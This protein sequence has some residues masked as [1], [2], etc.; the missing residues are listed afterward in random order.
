M[1][2]CT[3]VKHLGPSQE[4]FS[5]PPNQYRRQCAG[6]HKAKIDSRSHAVTVAQLHSA[7][8]NH[9][10]HNPKECESLTQLHKQHANNDLDLLAVSFPRFTVATKSPGR[11]RLLAFTVLQSLKVLCHHAREPLSRLLHQQSQ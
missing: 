9:V 5:K 6:S 4:G 1:K 2:N 11:L 10:A 8:E 7:E 3:Q